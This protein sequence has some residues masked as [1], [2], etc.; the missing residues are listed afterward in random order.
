MAFVFTCGQFCPLEPG[1]MRDPK[2][3]I[4]FIMVGRVL[5]LLFLSIIASDG[6]QAAPRPNILFMFSDD[7]GWGD[8]GCHGHPYLR[9][10]HIDR[11]AREGTD[12]RKRKK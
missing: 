1:E 2:R 11:L 7:W 10:P 12:F 3:E 6:V 9:T 8:L 4:R 5:L